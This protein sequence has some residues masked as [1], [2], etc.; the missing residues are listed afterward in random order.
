MTITLKKCTSEKNHLTRIF[1]SGE[2]SSATHTGTLRGSASLTDPVIQIPAT[3]DIAEFNYMEIPAFGRNYFITD[4]PV[5]VNGMWE[6]HAHV[7]VIG[8]WLEDIKDC[9][10]LIDEREKNPDYYMEDGNA[11]TDERNII[12][13]KKFK[14]PDGY[15]K[16]DD[17]NGTFRTDT[18][19]YVLIATGP[20]E[21][22]PNT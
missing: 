11:F 17:G 10:A 13:H 21:T 1:E 9:E 8:T 5:L 2:G 18:W 22:T 15:Y 4:L 6:I 20:G 16:D 19:E 14:N 7:D 3:S 12:Q